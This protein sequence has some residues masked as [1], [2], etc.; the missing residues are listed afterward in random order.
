[1]IMALREL[2]MRRTAD[3]EVIQDREEKGERT[4]WM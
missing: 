1:M 3:E 4:A 2:K